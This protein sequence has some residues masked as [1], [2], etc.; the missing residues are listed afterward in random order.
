MR[1][2][3]S[4]RTPGRC[5]RR[6]C[7]RGPTPETGC[8][9]RSRGRPA[10]ALQRLL[11]GRGPGMSSFPQAVILNV[12]DNESCRYAVTR[13]LQRNN[14]RVTEAS[15]GREALRL[16]RSEQP[17]LVLLD[18]HLPDMHGFEVCRQLKAEPATSRI[19]VMHI[20]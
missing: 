15:S 18:V 7:S 1:L 3:Y 4:T 17:D 9:P 10:W 2:L 11:P 6:K 16:A 14:F 19:P 12:D 8:A 13:T 20:T 5:C